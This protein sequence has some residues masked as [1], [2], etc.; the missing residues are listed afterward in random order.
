MNRTEILGAWIKLPYMAIEADGTI[1][2]SYKC[3]SCNGIGYF[4]RGEGKIVGGLFCP[5][6]GVRMEGGDNG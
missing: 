5:N 6:C 4:R 3:S 1:L 2:F